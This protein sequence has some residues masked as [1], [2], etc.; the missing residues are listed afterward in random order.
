MDPR[1]AET[2]NRNG[3]SDH[4][5]AFKNRRRSNHRTSRLEHH[6]KSDHYRATA[7]TGKVRETE[8]PRQLT[9]GNAPRDISPVTKRRNRNT[10][11]P[12]HSDLKR[13]G[14]SS[15][16]DVTNKLVV[17]H[18][19]HYSRHAWSLSLSNASGDASFEGAAL[20]FGSTTPIW[21]AFPSYRLCRA[22]ATSWG[23][24]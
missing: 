20:R 9:E 18:G 15:A 5:E 24:Q 17:M 16:T 13:S 11:S 23:R 21:I 22:I 2:N 4:R 8:T 3:N 19:V 12:R 14:C 7:T 1:R 10:E 6:A